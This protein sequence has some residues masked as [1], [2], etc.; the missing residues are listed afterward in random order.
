MR[1]LGNWRLEEGAHACLLDA[2]L[3]HLVGASVTILSK[4]VADM[5]TQ[6]KSYGSELE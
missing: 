6:A 1:T 2:R 3:R 4:G 5:A